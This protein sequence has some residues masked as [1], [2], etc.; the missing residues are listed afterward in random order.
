MGI[1]NGQLYG[2]DT[3][4]QGDTGFGGI[5]TL[6]NFLPT[7]GVTA[8]ELPGFTTTASAWSFVFESQ[9]R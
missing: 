1:Y 2:S 6:G 8:V 5:F 4:A 7:A 3:S 9:T